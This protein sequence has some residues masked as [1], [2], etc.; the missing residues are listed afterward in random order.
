[1][2]SYATSIT[3]DIPS[4]MPVR[5]LELMMSSYFRFRFSFKIQS[6]KDWAGLTI[7]QSGDSLTFLAVLTVSYVISSLN[8]ELVWSERLESVKGTKVLVGFLNT[9]LSVDSSRL[10]M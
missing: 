3:L 10:V 1:M 4:R 7:L 8:T 9:N 6:Q 5:A 2:F